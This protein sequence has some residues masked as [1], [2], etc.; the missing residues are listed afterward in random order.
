MSQKNTPERFPGLMMP[1]H[2]STTAHDG[3]ALGA[4]NVSEAVE[5]NIE[6]FRTLGFAGDIKKA[7]AELSEAFDSLANLGYAGHLYVRVPQIVPTSQLLTALDSRKP[8]NVE[9]A[10]LSPNL[11]TPGTKKHSMTQKEIDAA[12]AI[13]SAQLALFS[14]TP[15]YVADPILHHI[16]NN[17]DK[18]AQKKW[19][20]PTDKNQLELIKQDNEQLAKSIIGY[21]ITQLTHRDFAM[22]SLLAR[23]KGVAPGSDDYPLNNGNMLVGTRRSNDDNSFVG[24]VFSYK[25][26]ASFGSSNGNAYW[27]DG[28]GLSLSQ[29]AA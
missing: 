8:D 15:T 20:K 11:W 22:L 17:Y 28:V 26:R 16:D 27:S 14:A 10:Y 12:P 18:Y 24:Q 3:L 1:Q 5:I 7:S 19:G 21:E 25:G 9:A 6:A 2:D 4:P 13:P 23:I 29:K